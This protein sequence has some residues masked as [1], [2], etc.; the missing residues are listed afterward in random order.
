MDTGIELSDDEVKRLLSL[1][2]EWEA[3]NVGK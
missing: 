3:I 1:A 2:K